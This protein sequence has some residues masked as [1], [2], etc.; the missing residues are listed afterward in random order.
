MWKLILRVAIAAV[1]IAGL[2]VGVN[3]FVDASQVITSRGQ[4]QMAEL[5]LGGNIVAVP[6]NYNERVYQ[7]AIL[8]QMKEMPSTIVL[9][10]SRGTYL[11]EEITGYPNLF[12]H[13]VSGA[14]IEDYYAV[15]ELYMEKFGKYPERVILEISPWVL[16]EFNPELRWIEIFSYRNTIEKLYEKL[17]SR[18]PE[19]KNEVNEANPFDVDGKPFYSK[20]N[21]WFSLP[22]FQYNCYVISQKGLDAFRGNTAR[23]STDPDEAAELPDGSVRNPASQEKPNPQRLAQVR[24]ETGAVTFEYA[25]RMT[26][27]GVKESTALEALIKELQDHGAEVI[28]FLAPFSP[29]QCTYSFDQDLNPGFRL[30]EEYLRDLTEKKEIRLIGGYDSRAFGLTDEQYIDYSHPDKS[31]IKTVWESAIAAF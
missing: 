14:C 28:L 30:A 27:V 8:E 1:L 21:P 2:I 18:K 16:N 12:N 9:G 13:C 4:E 11:G 25:H 20:E 10:S 3:Y 15:P 7:T 24:A 23:I 29:T 22:Y 31:A 6:E 5:V 19:P 26:E 17:N